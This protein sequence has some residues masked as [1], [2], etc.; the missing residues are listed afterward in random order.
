MW[1]GSESGPIE[2]KELILQR[3]VE[4][5]EDRLLGIHR[6]RCQNTQNFAADGSIDSFD[7]SC[8]NTRP[9][10]LHRVPDQPTFVASTLDTIELTNRDLAPS[11]NGTSLTFFHTARAGGQ[12]N[13]AQCWLFSGK[14]IRQE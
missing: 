10:G 3:L 13:A 6:S 5:G 1:Q 4:V 9:I 7:I 14:S 12:L 2:R 11:G 8:H